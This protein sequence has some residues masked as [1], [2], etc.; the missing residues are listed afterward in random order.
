MKSRWKSLLDRFA[1]LSLRERLAVAAVLV[2]VVPI[3]IVMALAEPQWRATQVLSMEAAHLRGLPAGPASPADPNRAAEAELRALEARIRDEH[4]RVTARSGLLVP[5]AEMPRLI[6]SL[7]R[8]APG[9]KLVALRSL[10]SEPWRD[11]DAPAPGAGAAVAAATPAGPTGAAQSA[12]YRHG[13][14]IDLEGSWSDLQSWVA[15]AERSPKRLL[16]GQL[17]LKV[18]Q[19]P[20]IALRLRLHTLSMDPAWMQL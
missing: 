17:D 13:I 12:L 14:E 7:V 6:E 10:A 4:A 9:V 20:Q 5:P 8:K 19:Y 11:A 16:W 2:L 1:A 18:R 3:A 15:T